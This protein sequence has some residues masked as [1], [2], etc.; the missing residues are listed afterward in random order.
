M[1][2]LVGISPTGMEIIFSETYLGYISDSNITEEKPDVI[3]WVGEEYEIISNK[4][5]FKHDM[6]EK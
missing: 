4:G 3:S 1:K 5:V 6:S 2:T